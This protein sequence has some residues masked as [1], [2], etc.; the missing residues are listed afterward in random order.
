MIKTIILAAGE[1]TRMKSNRSKV[2]HK[3]LGQEMLQYII[4]ATEETDS[5][6]TIIIGGENFDKLTERYSDDDISF[7]KQNFGEDFPYGTG[8]AVSLCEEHIEDE[9]TV[10][11]LTGDT[12]LI[13]GNTLKKLLDFHKKEHFSATVLT[14]TIEDPTGYGRIVKDDQ[15]MFL[16]IVEEK[17]CTKEEKKIKEFNTGMLVVNGKAL[18]SALGDLEVNNEQNEMYLTDIFEILRRE[19][20]GIGCFMVKDVNEAYG[21]NSKNQ[22]DFAERIM[23]ERINNYWMTEGVILEQPETIVIGP[24]VRLSQDVLLTNGTRLLGKTFIDENTKV[25]G[26]TIIW[27]SNIGKNSRITQ[28]H[29]N[30]ATV[31]NFVTIGPFA[32]LRPETVLE[33]RV[34]IGNFVEV[35]NATMKKGSKAGH[36]AYIGDCEI[37][38]RVNIGCGVIFANYDGKNKHFSKI[39]NDAF[40]GSNTTIVSPITVEDEGYIAAGST[41][42]EDVPSHALGIA[43]GRQRNIEDWTKR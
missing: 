19:G 31:G 26:N 30:E 29:L 17:D 36:H 37:G 33:D 8:Y 15:N 14:A 32:H 4:D 27:D 16:K 28:S 20:H 39:G 42:T 11:I 21:I 25:I 5:K 9:D 43:R 41:I 13:R 1:G 6:E 12:P 10:L 3:L 24:K 35:K 34:H 40:I 7:V 38:E 2:F 23:Q 18:K 22:L